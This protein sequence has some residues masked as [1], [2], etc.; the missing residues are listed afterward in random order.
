M[1]VLSFSY[2]FP[3]RANPTWGIFVQQRLA[4]LAGRVD[5]QV[6]API[7]R[8]PLLRRF[9]GRGAPLRDRWGA[10]TVHRPRF[11]YVPGVL[12]SQDA[13]LYA[14]GLRRWLAD[15]CRRWRPD[16][17]DA[18]FIWP[19]GV[20]V[21]RLAGRVGLPYVITLRGRL[22]P[23]LEVRSQRRQCVEALR[24]AAA[25]I[26]VSTPM[27]ELAR[28]LG[29]R[30]DH[31]HVIPNGVDTARFRPR[32]KAAA[33][34]ELALPAD[35]PLI[36]SVAHLGP[37]KGHQ[38]TNRALAQLP[39]EVRLVIVGGD[40]EGGRNK[41][42]LRGLIDELALEDRVILIGRE[43]YDRVA[44]YFNAGDLSVLASHREG[45]PNVVLESLAS[46]T[47]TVTTNVGAAPDLVL[48]PEEGRLVAP[49]DADALARAIQEVLGTPASA[50]SVAGAEA[51]KSWDAVADEILEIFARLRPAAENR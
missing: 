13:R 40:S 47:P 20:G 1:R 37:R 26:S 44:L 22:Y 32:D 45:C 5:L 2:C 30:P 29:A 42:A 35:G 19:D 10:L 21:A 11:F 6:A 28:E 3:S 4:A 9:G 48:R 51:V 18:H 41:R 8:F 46:G 12:K 25:V 17:L 38:E 49:H 16:L 7:P 24:G 33:R 34:R 23:C 36:V 14:R 15:M 43:S 31:V 50:A 39:P 27:A